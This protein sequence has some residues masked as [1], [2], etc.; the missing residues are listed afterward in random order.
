[1]TPFNKEAIFSDETMQFVTPND[2]APG[3]LVEIRLR[4]LKDNIHTA[5][6]HICGNPDK[7]LMNKTA[8]DSLFDYYTTIIVAAENELRYF[9]EVDNIFYNK[10]GIHQNLDP[11]YH[12]RLASGINVPKWATGAVMYHI[13]VDRFK[14]GDPTNDVVDHEYAYLGVT[15]KSV[16]WG[17][18]V[19]M[20]DVCNFQGGDL[21]GIMQKM[22]YLQS[23]GI[24]VLFLS[25]VFVSPSNHKYDIQDYDYIDP[26]FGAIVDDS[27]ESLRFEKVH[28]RYATKYRHRTASIKNLEASNALMVE[29]IELAHRH[30]MRVILDGV[31]NHCGCF[32]K[33]MDTQ[34]F[35]KD[36]GY[37]P[38]AYHTEDSPYNSYFLWHKHKWPNNNDYD[39][40]W[41]NSNHPK[42]N[43][44]DSPELCEYIME[45][46]K[47]WV[48]PP[49]NAD[50]W[51]LDVA[52]D[53]GRTR[54]FNHK[55]WRAFRVAVKEANPDAIILAENYGD[56]S[57]WLDGTQWDTI[58][59]YDAFM[60]PITWFLTGVSK[61]SDESRPHLK[62]N[63]MAFENAMRYSMTKLNIHAMQ[64]SMNQLSNHDHSRFLTR[65]IGTTG[66]HNTV[67]PRAAEIGTNKNILMEAIV[68]QMTWPGAP[69]VYYGDEAGL[70]GWTDP[71]SRR[72]FPWGKEDTNLIELHRNLI[73]IRRMYP[74]LKTGSVEFLWT[75]HGFLS[76]GR[77]DDKQKIVVA[78]NNNPKPIEVVLPVWKLGVID[79][80]MMQL[81]ITC[82]DGFHRD[83]IWYHVN[84]G[85]L[86]ITIPG[87]GA[88]ILG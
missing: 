61:H 5:Q 45:I 73:G 49:F 75:N 11:A 26:H 66:R 74:V 25:P 44:E 35:Y 87:F 71:D 46:A 56:S 23:L 43:F 20:L 53:L 51:R 38:G 19:Q 30:G 81:I 1:M 2:P 60:E 48:S 31:F 84:K 52:A 33:W 79:G 88:M 64:S 6:L 3:D 37:P 82:D 4:T 36:A 68:F 70:A 86:K 8:S 9:F 69:T 18:D 54:E 59:N 40:W 12:F 85:E 62:N 72:P 14:N 65:T 16:P 29:F 13:F 83:G 80:Q 24:E 67:G 77:W 39:G 55:F 17:S 32:N 28:N 34:S 78:I 21:R 58:M 50:G 27:G 42:L 10:G 7:F 63:A 41:D 47:K 76:Y 57:S 22:G 15:A